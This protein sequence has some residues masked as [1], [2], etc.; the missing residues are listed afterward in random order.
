LLR[1]EAE[2][3]GNRKDTD[4]W[5]QQ[6]RAATSEFEKRFWLFRVLAAAQTKVVIDLGAEID[7]AVGALSPK[8]YRAMEAAV[9]AFQQSSLARGLVLQEALRLAQ[10]T[11]SGRTL[12]LLRLAATEGSV[13][14]IDRKLLDAFGELLVP[15][16]GDRRSL[17]RVL[18]NHKTVPID[19]LENARCVLPAGDWAGNVKLGAMR[20]ATAKR[21]L[22]RPEAWPLEVVDRAIQQSAAQLSKLPPVSELAQRNHWFDPPEG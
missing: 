15:G 11:Y 1:G 2:M 14:H 5:R 13:E 12:W 17:M 9:R 16:M 4:W 19:F 8:H 6:W 10:V 21:V 20:S 18:G 3:R 7:Q 22:E